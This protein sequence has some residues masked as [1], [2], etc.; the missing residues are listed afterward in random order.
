FTNLRLLNSGRNDVTVVD[1]DDVTFA[2]SSTLGT[3]RLTVTAGGNITEP[4]TI[5]QA[6]TGPAGDVRFVST[7][8]SVNL[9]GN[10]GLRGAVS[11]TVAGANTATVNNPGAA[12]TL[13]DVTTG[14]GAFTAGSGN[15]SLVQDPN[16]VL[17][18]GGTSSFTAGSVISLTNRTN[19]FGGAVA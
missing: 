2:S 15:T 11:V 7:G 6:N 17:N 1:V 14:V 19:T 9:L 8:G 5:T 10:T 16:S 3:G 18:L 4:G 13:G 12:L